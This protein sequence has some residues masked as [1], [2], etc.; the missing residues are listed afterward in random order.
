VGFEWLS[1]APASPPTITHLSRWK[2]AGNSQ[3]HTLYLIRVTGGF[4]IVDSVSV[5]MATGSDGSWV[6]TALGSPF[7]LSSA[8][9]VYGIM[10]SEINGGDGWY[11]DDTSIGGLYS[12]DFSAQGS[13]YDTNTP[14]TSSTLNTSGLFTFV[15]VNAVLTP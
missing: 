7:T 10:S 1:N 5:D 14:P 12:A 3:T 11:N 9:V 8:A 13:I 4:T 6:S 15:P 2:R